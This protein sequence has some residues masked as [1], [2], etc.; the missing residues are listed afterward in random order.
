ME[1]LAKQ[2]VL[3][4]S[5][6]DEPLTD[7]QIKEYMD[8]L[9]GWELTSHENIPCI[10]RVYTFGDFMGAMDFAGRVAEIAEEAHHHP[11]LI[12]SWG[13]CRVR[14][15]TFVGERLHDNDFIMAART[16]L[17]YKK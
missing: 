8:Q 1:K 6:F 3:T 13:K 15:W 11:D 12:I 5:K 4:Y 10:E 14:W 7:Q 2:D 16:E 17:L 9:P